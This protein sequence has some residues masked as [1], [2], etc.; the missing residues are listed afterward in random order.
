MNSRV[1]KINYRIKNESILI[2]LS[3]NRKLKKGGDALAK[4]IK[5][6]FDVRAKKP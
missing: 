4:K 2:L 6:R 3:T 5:L 1:K